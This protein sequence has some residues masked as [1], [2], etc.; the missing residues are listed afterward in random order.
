MEYKELMENEK[1]MQKAIFHSQTELSKIIK[2][3][4]ELLDKVKSIIKDHDYHTLI[5]KEINDLNELLKEADNSIKM[6]S[7]RI[8]SIDF[9][10]KLLESQDSIEN[11]IKRTKSN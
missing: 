2:E 3:R 4:F 9:S 10:L 8:K 6:A 11:I 1:K 7:E 5:D